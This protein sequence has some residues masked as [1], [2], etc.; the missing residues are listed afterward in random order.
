MSLK[1]ISSVEGRAEGENGIPNPFLIMY[2]NTLILQGVDSISS[3]SIK[4]GG[5]KESSA[6][7]TIHKLVNYEF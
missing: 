1:V 6:F 2:P 3:P 5:V 4:S 7:I